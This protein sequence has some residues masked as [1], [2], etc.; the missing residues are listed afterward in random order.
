MAG[1]LE[2]FAK[3]HG[4]KY[5]LFNFTDLRGAQRSKLVPASAAGAMETDGAG[6]AGFATWLDMT[7]RPPRHVLGPRR[8]EPRSASM[9]AGSGVGRGRPGDGRRTG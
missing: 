9:E 8:G 3:K 1:K 7:P 4:V 6:F 5:F 2:A